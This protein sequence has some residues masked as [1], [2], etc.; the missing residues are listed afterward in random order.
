MTDRKA[1]ID[2]YKKRKTP[3]GIYLLTHAGS[4]LRWVGHAA[5]LDAIMN[6][7]LF[8]LRHGS[9]RRA[10]LQA[11]WNADGE[12]LAFEI[13]ETFEADA[14]P[15]GEALKSRLRDWRARLDALPL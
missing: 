14:A 12:N 5:D 4:G 11:A 3:A 10:D 15:Q 13:V 2:R 8:T 9:H 7:I 6:R 1:A